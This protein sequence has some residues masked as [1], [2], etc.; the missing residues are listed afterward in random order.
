MFLNNNYKSDDSKIQMIRSILEFNDF[1]M[2]FKTSVLDDIMLYIFYYSNMRI[3]SM[4]TMK[5]KTCNEVN[6][7]VFGLMVVATKI[8]R[9]MEV[10]ENET[11]FEG[12]D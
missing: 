1:T 8:W 9:N 11:N 2:N 4:I 3:N 6:R 12:N 5:K 10:Y 7:I